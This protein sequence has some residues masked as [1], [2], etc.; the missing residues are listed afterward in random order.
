[1]ACIMPDQMD[2]IFK[3]GENEAKHSDRAQQREVKAAP[4]QA[5]SSKV[6]LQSDSKGAA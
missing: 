6:E 1:M 4:V 5:S 3:K 2:I